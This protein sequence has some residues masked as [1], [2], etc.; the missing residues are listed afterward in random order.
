MFRW[1]QLFLYQTWND[2]NY[3]INTTANILTLFQSSSENKY[4]KKLKAS[5]QK[6]KFDAEMDFFFGNKISDSQTENWNLF[7]NYIR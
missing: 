6:N 5:Y 4:I 1:V 3:N 7:Y 2:P